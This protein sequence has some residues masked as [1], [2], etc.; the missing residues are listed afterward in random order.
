MVR[1]TTTSPDTEAPSSRWRRLQQ[2]ASEHGEPAGL[3]RLLDD[4]AWLYTPAFLD[5]GERALRALEQMNELGEEIHAFVD[6]LVR[7]VAEQTKPTKCLEALAEL[8]AAAWLIE[9]GV[10]VCDAG[11]LKPANNVIDLRATID[12]ERVGVEVKSDFDAFEAEIMEGQFEDDPDALGPQ[13]RARF[14]DDVRTQFRWIG[15]RPTREDWGPI[16]TG[17]RDEVARAIPTAP[18]LPVGKE[19]TFTAML[20]NKIGRCFGARVVVSRGPLVNVSV[21]FAGSG[22]EEVGRRIGAHAIS[23]ASR[24]DTPFVLLYVSQAPQAASMDA[25]RLAEVKRHYLSGREAL[26]ALF[27]GVLHLQLTPSETQ[28]AVARGFLTEGAVITED[29]FKEALGLA[30]LPESTSHALVG[31][32]SITAGR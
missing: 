31:G 1:D 13:L 17:V 5:S 21:Q 32:V 4:G 30:K 16:R 23:K 11:M 15:E 18:D 2:I 12:G 3:S 9:R 8:V 7:H 14:G 6:S 22:W 29:A 28:A 26:P 20:K 19:L 27:L 24:T 10:L 25:S